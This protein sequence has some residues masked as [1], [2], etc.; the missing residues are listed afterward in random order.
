MIIFFKSLDLDWGTLIQDATVLLHDRALA[1]ELPVTLPT[2]ARD[3]VI[4]VTCC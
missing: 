4:G 3:P 2:G 1:R